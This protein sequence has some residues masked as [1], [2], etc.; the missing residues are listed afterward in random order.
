MTEAR[1]C[2]QPVE[3]GQVLGTLLDPSVITRLILGADETVG[4]AATIG[5]HVQVASSLLDRRLD[6]ATVGFGSLEG[7][8]LSLGIGEITAQL[9]ATRA[10]ASNRARPPPVLRSLQGFCG[11]PAQMRDTSDT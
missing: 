4:P 2:V 6:M 3:I 7:P 1:S 9:A 8:A 5:R 10:L 11:A